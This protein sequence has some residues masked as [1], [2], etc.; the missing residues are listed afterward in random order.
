MGELFS[1]NY[2]FTI[3]GVPFTGISSDTTTGGSCSISNATAEQ[4][5]CLL[6]PYQVKKVIFH[7]PAT[8]VIWKD[9]SKTVVKCYNEPYDREKGLAMCIAK[10]V[11]GNKFH[12]LFREWCE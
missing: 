10:K 8:I 5:S 12:Q 4:Y 7:D 6:F 3:G 2:T 11:F 9:N 1:S